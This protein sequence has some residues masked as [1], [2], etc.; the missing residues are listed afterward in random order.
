MLHGSLHRGNTDA[1]KLGRLSV[2]Q[3][4]TAGFALQQQGRVLQH[5]RLRGV[6][7]SAQINACDQAQMPI[8]AAPLAAVFA[9]SGQAQRVNKGVDIA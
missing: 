5:Q 6:H 3:A 4:D 7:G 1:F 8:R 9:S 2:M